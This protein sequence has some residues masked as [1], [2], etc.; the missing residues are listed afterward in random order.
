[1][2]GSEGGNEPDSS[3]AAFEWF[4]RWSLYRGRLI[5]PTKPPFLAK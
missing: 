4:K 2:P 5:E 1:M 3:M